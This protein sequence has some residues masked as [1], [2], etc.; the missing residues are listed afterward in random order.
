MKEP[1]HTYM[2]RPVTMQQ[3]KEILEEYQSK[4]VSSPAFGD[5]TENGNQNREES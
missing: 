2:G 3:L 4:P 1:T 5:H